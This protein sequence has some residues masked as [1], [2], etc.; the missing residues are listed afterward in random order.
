MIPYLLVLLAV[1][2]I[3][4]LGRIANNRLLRGISLGTVGLI[5]V[6]FAGLRDVSVGT[7]TG[8]YVRQFLRAD[9]AASITRTTE[10]G[11][12]FLTW[13][14]R[15]LTD[16]Y[17][18]LLTLIAVIVVGC[19]LATIRKTVQR[20]ETAIFVFVCLGVY[21]FFFN[22]A[23][24]GIAAALC[25]AAL[26]YLLERRVLPYLLIVGMATLF[27]H[28]ALVALPLYYLISPRLDI[29]RLFLVA[30]ATLGLIVLLEAFVELA[31]ELVSDKYASYAQKGKGGGAVLASFLVSQGIGF[32]LLRNRI[33]NFKEEYALLFNIYLI[34]LVPVVAAVVTDVNPSGLLRFHLYFSPVSILLW[35]MIFRN[36][37][38]SS[39]RAFFGFMFIV[40]MMSFFVM[41]TRTFSDLAPYK[42][43]QDILRVEY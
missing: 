41:T 36:V 30:G 8:T 43:N 17:A 34:G 35:P 29:T 16:S 4:Y 14:I 26:P 6:G 40:F 2:V 27:H 12:T 19:Y 7:D 42:T 33:G 13:S 5:L 21:T 15:E 9:V 28:T 18:V 10:V 39:E 23:R 31:T 38:G 22:G 32:F 24:Q 1:V 11:Y 37:R 20:Y 3:A 25:F